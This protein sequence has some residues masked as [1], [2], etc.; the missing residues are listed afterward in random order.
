M[1]HFTFHL[2]LLMHSALGQSRAACQHVMA[3]LWAKG[4]A[5]SS[6]GFLKNADPSQCRAP[7]RCEHAHSVAHLTTGT[8]LDYM[9][10]APG[11]PPPP[12]HAPKHG[13]YH[14]LIHLNVCC[15]FS[16]SKHNSVRASYFLFYFIFFTFGE[17]AAFSLM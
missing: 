10:A 9:Q 12:P 4:T 16:L 6:L 14:F 17:Y 5:A 2:W 3:D 8:S 7:L 1:L 15:F 13:F 11:N